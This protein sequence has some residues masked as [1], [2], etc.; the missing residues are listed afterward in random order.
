MEEYL[1]ERRD[2]VQRQI[3][4]RGICDPRLLAA[5]EAIPR[6]L[7]VPFEDRW[8]AYQDRALP[9]GFGQTISQPYIVAL[10]TDLLCLKG[11]ERVLEVGTGSGY[12][13][14]VL[15]FLAAEVYTIELDSHLAE[16]AREVLSGLNRVN[17]HFQT[18]DGSAGWPQAAPFNGILVTAF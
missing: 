8:S 18:A 11:D 14:A 12:Q 5:L 6:H 3:A 4:G 17:I 2:M 1:S 9:I 16:R 15:S 7:F 10:M 13:A